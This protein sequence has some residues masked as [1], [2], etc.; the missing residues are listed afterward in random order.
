V[1]YAA[2][3]LVEALRYKPEGRGLDSNGLIGIFHWFNPSGR[4]MA[5]RS[6]GRLTEMS[7]RNISSADYLEILR[8][9]T[10]WSPEDLYIKKHEVWRLR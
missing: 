2:A 4:S 3:L 7:T 9:S 1:N 6:T 5:L 10:Y 8:A